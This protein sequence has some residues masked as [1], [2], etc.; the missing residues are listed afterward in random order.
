MRH[1]YPVAVV[2]LA[3]LL[4]LFFA[5]QTN[6]G[7]R[8]FGLPEQLGISRGFSYDSYPID[9]SAVFF[10]ASD[11]L[12]NRE[13][14][15]DICLQRA[16]VQAAQFY[17][18]DFTV[19]LVKKRIGR[20]SGAWENIELHW[21]RELEEKLKDD[22]E[23]IRVVQHNTGT[24]AFARLRTARIEELPR[25]LRNEIGRLEWINNPP[26]IPD[27]YSAVGIAQRKRSFADSVQSADRN[28]MAEL[29]R[30]VTSEVKSQQDVKSGA[31]S[32]LLLET[33]YEV[34]SVAIT[35]FYV[36]H[37]FVSDDS[38]YFYSLAICRRIDERKPN[39][40]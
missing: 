9:G 34:A 4:S 5:C 18:V 35:G 1:K 24:Y 22:L 30:Q 31:N 2:V 32:T 3:A 28:A 23:L 13:E 8:S 29:V 16:A 14:E 33:S 39:Q 19:K 10:S 11:R 7:N 17:T 40:Q 36:L 27:F 20:V 15:V 38:N 21:D 37:R 6:R 25:G 12:L 26:K